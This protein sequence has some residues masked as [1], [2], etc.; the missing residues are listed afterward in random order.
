MKNLKSKNVLRVFSKALAIG[1]ASPTKKV[2]LGFMVVGILVLGFATVAYLFDDICT[3]AGTPPLCGAPQSL[4][5]N[6]E[7]PL[8]NRTGD[9]EDSILIADLIL[10]GE[11]GNPDPTTCDDG[12]DNGPDGFTDFSDPDCLDN[13]STVETI[14]LAGPVEIERYPSPGPDGTTPSAD[15]KTHV[16]LAGDVVDGDGIPCPGGPD[17][18]LGNA[19]DGPGPDGLY[20]TGDD[21]L[22][23]GAEDGVIGP[24]TCSNGLD[25]GGIDGLIDLGD[26]D[27]TSIPPNDTGK[28]QIDT[29]MISMNLTGSSALL[30]GATITVTEPLSEVATGV[31]RNGDGD[32]TDT[33]Q[34]KG[35]I[36]TESNSPSGDFNFPA[37][38]FFDVFF[39]ITVTGFGTGLAAPTERS[40][41]LS[42][43]P[44]SCSDTIDNDG[45]TLIDLADPDCTNGEPRR[46]SSRISRIAPLV[47][48]GSEG[49]S[50]SP[51]CSDGTDN[52]GDT[53]IDLADPDCQVNNTY[54]HVG[55]CIVIQIGS[56]T[57]ML[58]NLK[59]KLTHPDYGDAFDNHC[60]GPFPREYASC[61][62]HA[63][64]ATHALSDIRLGSLLSGEPDSIQPDADNDDGVV[65]DPT[66]MVGNQGTATFTVTVD[67]TYVWGGV[68]DTLH[69][70]AWFDFNHDDEWTDAPGNELMFIWTGRPKTGLAWIGVVPG[71]GSIVGLGA[72][73]GGVWPVGGPLSCSF[74]AKFSV[75]AGTPDGTPYFARFRLK[76]GSASTMGPT[77]VQPHGEV[78]DWKFGQKSTLI[79]LLFFDVTPGNGQVIINW[80][81][82]AEIDNYGFNILRS[83][84]PGGPFVRINSAMIPAMGIS[85]GGATY[86]FVDMAVESGKAYYYRL[87]DIDTH[88]KV[89]AHNI[90]SATPMYA[91]G[92]PK[93]TEE[94]STASL[95]LPSSG[96]EKGAEVAT[97]ST[98]EG[99]GSGSNST[100]SSTPSQVILFKI[101]ESGNSL[102]IARLEATEE[103]E[104]ANK[105][106]SP[107]RALAFKALPGDREITLEWVSSDPDERFNILRSETEKGNYVQINGALIS[108]PEEEV[109]R[110][111]YSYTDTTVVEGTTYYYK[112]ERITLEGD[113]TLIGPIPAVTQ[114]VVGQAGSEPEKVKEIK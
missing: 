35:K 39:D 21:G 52:D 62:A 84:S 32:T 109:D 20:A 87:E 13:G 51:T 56:S 63:T 47:P 70:K 34:S 93:S 23:D 89:T 112:L 59:H 36:T 4:T 41:G 99:A 49:P 46:V 73:A 75:P 77:G 57:V 66:Y 16:V 107:L 101:L 45:D 76:K 65:L 1:K 97:S 69:V 114:M 19:D 108:A 9:V 30:G 110:M 28:H 15:D 17:G 33:N 24:N 71:G 92:S 74:T 25:D 44:A 72:C 60:G 11:D 111:K 91:G 6:L 100:S 37:D 106:Q 82:G 55:N 54:K 103:N 98:N 2:S 105:E 68:H 22:C 113:T 90:V 3:L 40:D 81:T 31:D 29:E 8:G 42:R 85:P 96:S 38:S 26:P 50:G 78:E 80:T 104:T 61:N 102:K 86:S 12:V 94:S 18:I 95:T 48:P 67:P 7:D 27:C 88:G 79:T 83:D 64:R 5:S 14:A 10:S 58:C 43:P 53:L